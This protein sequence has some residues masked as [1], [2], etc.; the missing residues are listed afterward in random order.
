MRYVWEMVIY[1]N[2]LKLWIVLVKSK[3]FNILQFFNVVR[4]VHSSKRRVQI[5]LHGRLINISVATDGA[6][7]A[8]PYS[9]LDW[10]WDSYKSDEKRL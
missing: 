6:Y 7:G 8:G 10:S 2:L 4:N 3:L 1:K 5:C 9:G